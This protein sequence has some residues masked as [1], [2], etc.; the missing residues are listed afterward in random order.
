[1]AIHEADELDVGVDA[2]TRS[3]IDFSTVF[4]DKNADTAL[5]VRPDNR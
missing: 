4:V 3:S 5:L 2:V 1:L